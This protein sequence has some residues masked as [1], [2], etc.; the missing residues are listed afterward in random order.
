M[1]K[2]Y[3]ILIFF[4]LAS[5]NAY[6]QE[7]S[8]QVIY[9][10]VRPYGDVKIDSIT[11]EVKIKK[12]SNDEFSLIYTSHFGSNEYQ[13]KFKFQFGDSKKS[14]RIKSESDNE[15]ME[16][17]VQLN[18]I[19]K[20]S[21][22]LYNKKYT[23]YKYLYNLKSVVDEETLIFFTKDFGIVMEKP[24]SWPGYRKLVQFGDLNNQ[25]ILNKLCEVILSDSNFFRNDQIKNK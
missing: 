19:D 10:E 22:N 18:L 1:T 25:K 15:L 17:S 11:K 7:I 4:L 12:I 9:Q 23:I 2:P 3:K 14:Y 8:K 13:Q 24:I 21:I 16:D 20:K 5:I 6:G